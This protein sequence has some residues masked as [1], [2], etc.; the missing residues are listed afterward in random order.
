MSEILTK[1]EDIIKK[2]T[3]EYRKYD[4]ELNAL[5]FDFD[6]KGTKGALLIAYAEIQEIINGDAIVK[7]DTAGING[8]DNGRHIDEGMLDDSYR[9]VYEGN[10][11]DFLESFNGRENETG[12][13]RVIPDNKEDGIVKG[14][15]VSFIF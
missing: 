10:Y 11:K 15:P 7:S 14:E 13:F 8:F 2:V 5:F 6:V 12:L 1:Q 4:T 9:E 3:D